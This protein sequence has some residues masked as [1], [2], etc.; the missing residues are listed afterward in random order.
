MNNCK[1]KMM[2][3]VSALKKTA[4]TKE[5]ALPPATKLSKMLSHSTFSDFYK[6][7]QRR[8]YLGHSASQTELSGLMRAESKNGRLNDLK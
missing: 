6:T 2:D 8:N 7:E 1:K 5:D 4:K 3:S